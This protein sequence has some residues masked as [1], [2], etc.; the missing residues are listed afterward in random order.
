MYAVRPVAL[1]A[2]LPAVVNAN[3]VKADV[4]QRLS[5][6]TFSGKSLYLAENE[7]LIDLE[8]NKDKRSTQ[9]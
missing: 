5:I 4:E 3:P 2:H 8:P 9:G 1:T 6:S 7:V